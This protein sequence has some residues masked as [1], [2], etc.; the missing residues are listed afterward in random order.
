MKK[1]L[2]FMTALGWRHLRVSDRHNPGDFDHQP[3]SHLFEPRNL[4]QDRVAL[5]AA[6]NFGGSPHYSAG[7]GVAVRL[8]HEPCTR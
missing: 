8:T 4:R 3:L 5:A 7:R 1:S 6:Q 2:A